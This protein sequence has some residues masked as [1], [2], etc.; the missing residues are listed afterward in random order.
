MVQNYCILCLNLRVVAPKLSFYV[1]SRAL[2]DPQKKDL[3][4]DPDPNL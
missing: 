1:E 4:P 3:D 2:D